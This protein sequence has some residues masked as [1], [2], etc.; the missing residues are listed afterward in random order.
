MI[1]CL[2][3]SSSLTF[4]D[5]AEF[6]SSSESSGKSDIT[7]GLARMVKADALSLAA[8]IARQLTERRADLIIKKLEFCTDATLDNYGSP[9]QK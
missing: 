6:M 3:M 5:I 4:S 9:S 7:S 2:I 8:S 1:R